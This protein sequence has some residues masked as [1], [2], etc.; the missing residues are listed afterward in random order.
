MNSFALETR[1]LIAQYEHDAN[2][3]FI[4]SMLM[5]SLT[6]TLA[7]IGLWLNCIWFAVPAVITLIVAIVS[8]SERAVA[9]DMIRMI[10][11]RMI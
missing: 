2:I 6:G 10:K 3:A 9:L 8:M 7:A 5:F 4:I 1:R 11:W